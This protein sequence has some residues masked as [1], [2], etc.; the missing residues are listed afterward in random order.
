M[1]IFNFL[2]LLLCIKLSAQPPSPSQVCPPDIS[3]GCNPA[4]IPPPDLKF[5]PGPG[6]CKIISKNWVNDVTVNVGCDY[7]LTRKYILV[8]S[9]GQTILCEQRIRWKKDLLPPVLRCPRDTFL[10]CNPGPKE[11]LVAPGGQIPAALVPIA[12]DNCD[13]LI[14]AN[15]IKDSVVKIGCETHIYRKW[16]VRDGCGNAAICYQHIWYAVDTKPPVITKCPDTLYLGCNPSD[17]LPVPTAFPVAT[18]NCGL[19]DILWYDGLND[20]TVTNCIATRT[21]LWIVTDR[22]GNQA[23]C[24]QK[25]RWKIDGISPVI[26]NCPPDR[27]YGCV[28]ENPTLPVP[29]WKG[30]EIT[31]ACPGPLTRSVQID[32]SILDGCMYKV[33]YLY[34]VIDECGNKGICVQTFRW[35]LIGRTE[36]V[37][38]PF[39]EDQKYTCTLPIIQTNHIP[40][41]CGVGYPILISKDTIGNYP[42]NY[43][44]IVVWRKYDCFG[45][46]TEHE[47]KIQVTCEITPGLNSPIIESRGVNQWQKIN[48]ETWKVTLSAPANNGMLEIVDTY[49]RR[50]YYSKIPTGQTFFNVDTHQLG[51]GIY[52]VVIRDK[53]SISTQKIVVSK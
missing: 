27:N 21:R 50:H 2:I 7:T 51:T 35:K 47:Q 36:L 45:N 48:P 44:I 37:N 30:I 41:V 15:F 4:S 38:I 43:T 17:Q 29:S 39:P 6:N 34:K 40:G 32:T 24:E 31:E 8:T 14:P 22:C 26:E 53:Q 52:F 33:T 10:G 19:H 49:G 3:L 25:I 9:C 11:A 20:V 23:R 42:S 28:K 16:G 18:D 1:K 13:G 12:V 5:K 46:Y